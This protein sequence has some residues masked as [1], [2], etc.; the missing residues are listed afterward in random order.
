MKLK[1]KDPKYSVL[2]IGLILAAV[3]TLLF[4]VIPASPNLTV[5]YVFCLL[6]I[7]LMLGSYLF[8]DSRNV[9]ASYA[10]IW[11]AGRFLPIS[12]V[13]SVTVLVLE[14][15]GIFTLP[16]IW[17]V[18]LQILPLA[19]VAIRLVQV[20]GGVAY[21]DQV[22]EKV[23]TKRNEW[24]AWTN[25]L[26]VLAAA[27]GDAQA[28]RAIQKAVEAMRYADPLG[29]EASRAV[30]DRIAETI[31]RIQVKDS[32]ARRELCEQLVLLIG[33]RNAVTKSSK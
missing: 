20:S 27:E 5:S 31:E 12:L 7:A 6:G 9:A 8:A 19:F 1:L 25:Q 14:R 3:A 4:I 21:V 32:A 17:H 2:L 22:E 26:N 18:V 28:K 13:L 30:E 33:E 11:Q 16:V 24:V 29:T 10:L 23:D 15:I